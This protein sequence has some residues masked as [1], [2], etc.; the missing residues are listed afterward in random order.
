MRLS[1][2]ARIQATVAYADVFDYP[3]TVEEV[4]LWIIGAPAIRKGR[5]GQI[6]KV[7]MGISDYMV[8]PGRQRLVDLRRKRHY[9]AKDKWTRAGYVAHFF[10]WIPTVVLVG[11][12]GGL[13]MKNTKK[14]DDIDLF[15]ITSHDTLWISRFLVYMVTQLLGVR[16]VPDQAQVMDTICPNMFMSEVSLAVSSAERDL[17]TAHEVLQ[18]RPLWEREGVYARFLIANTWVKSFLPNAWAEKIKA[19]NIK[20]QVTNKHQ[21]QSTK[22]QTFRNFMFKYCLR[23]GIWCLRFLEQPSRLLQLWYMKKRRTSEVIEPGVLRFHPRDARIWVRN[24]YAKRLKM[25]N[26]PLDK[27]FYHR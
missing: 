9:I 21:A 6:Q 19:S 2:H 1:S 15:I 7:R 4:D 25:L 22:L 24:K 14:D 3:L 23:F 10:R 13:S 27:I 17:F 16:R 26:L 8:L 12:T 20:H 11:V 5:D 18:M